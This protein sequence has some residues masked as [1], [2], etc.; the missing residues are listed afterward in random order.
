[1]IDNYDEQVYEVFMELF[2]TLPLACVVEG[3]YLAMHG[4]ISPLFDNIEEINSIH[5]FTEVPL[6]GVFCDLLWADPMKDDQALRGKFA[7]NI[8]R[9]CSVWFGKKPTESILKQ[10]GLVSVIRGHQVQAEGYKMHKWD[11][12]QSF[13]Y[14][15]TVFSAPN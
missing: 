5:R 14:V 7:N 6:E 9:D 15:I 8:D 10:N 4:G 2:D 11:G 13:P 3:R 1:M 12:P